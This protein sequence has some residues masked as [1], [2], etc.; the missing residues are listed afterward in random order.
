MIFKVPGPSALVPGFWFSLRAPP[1][2]CRQARCNRWGPTRPGRPHEGLSA[3]AQVPA[4]PAQGPDLL[5]NRTLGAATAPAPASTLAACPILQYPHNPRLQ[6]HLRASR[7]PKP[8]C[9]KDFCCFVGTLA[10]STLLLSSEVGHL[11]GFRLANPVNIF[12]SLSIFRVFACETSQLPIPQSMILEPSNILDKFG[13]GPN[14]HLDKS[15]PSLR[16]CA[17]LNM[18]RAEDRPFV[19]QLPIPLSS[20]PAP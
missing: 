16:P 6:C 11:G 17:P 15:R 19:F 12:A 5:Q 4:G 10:C 18:D 2:R 20:I 3:P 13:F 1:G 14:V 8:A 7:G 9:T